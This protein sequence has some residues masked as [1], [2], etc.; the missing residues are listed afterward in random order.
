MNGRH[1]LK[2]KIVL[3]S[4]IFA[5]LIL[6]SGCDQKQENQR[7]K[8]ENEQLKEQLSS[9]KMENEQLKVQV[10]TLTDINNNLTK[11]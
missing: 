5:T 1:V 6:I 8:M 4:M 3:L 2:N 10:S 9:L 7:L 11:K